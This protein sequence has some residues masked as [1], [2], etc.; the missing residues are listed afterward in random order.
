MTLFEI[1]MIRQIEKVDNQ[2]ELRIKMLEERKAQLLKQKQ[3]K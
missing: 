3:T 1:E 2:I